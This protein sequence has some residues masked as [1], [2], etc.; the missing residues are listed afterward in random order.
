MS[1]FT[2]QGRAAV[3]SRYT[4][5][6]DARVQIARA[7]GQVEIIASAVLP[8][9]GEDYLVHQF[10]AAQ[11]ALPMYAIATALTSGKVVPVA[12]LVS[13][14]AS[15]NKLASLKAAIEKH[16]KDQAKQAQGR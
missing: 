7:D 11:T 2:T 5:A 4:L 16:E 15:E 6:P 10:G 1:G 8:A 9:S 14:F 3:K 12:D 13:A